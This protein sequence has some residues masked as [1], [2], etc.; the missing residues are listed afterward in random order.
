MAV[1]KYILIVS[2]ALFAASALLVP[3]HGHILTIGQLRKCADLIH[4]AANRY[5]LDEKI[6]AAVIYA[7]RVRNV[8][9]FDRFDHFRARIGYDP[10]I[11]LAQ[12]KLSTA[13]WLLDELFE[14]KA[15]SETRILSRSV[16][17][18][19]LNDSL[20]I[21]I[22]AMY[23]SYIDTL[24]LKHFG[25]KAEA[26]VLA[27]YYSRGLDFGK[28]LLRDDYVNPVGREAELFMEKE[29]YRKIFSNVR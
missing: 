2:I 7:E 13:T 17:D 29:K 3:R 28:T 9:Y 8:N 25:H 21:D 26:A 19:L 6:L 4:S 12:V 22:A 16:L 24:Y 1:K 18:T 27:S 11:G 20:N 5:Q 10:S 23:V 15:D 14:S